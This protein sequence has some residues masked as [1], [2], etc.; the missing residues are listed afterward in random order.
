[1]TNTSRASAVGLHRHKRT[2][3]DIGLALKRAVQIISDDPS[4]RQ[5][6]IL[7]LTDGDFATT[8]PRTVAQS[9]AEFDEAAVEAVQRGIKVYTIALSS[10]KVYDTTRLIDLAQASGGLFRSGQPDQPAWPAGRRRAGA[11]RRARDAP[12]LAHQRGDRQHPRDAGAHHAQP[13][14]GR[15]ARGGDRTAPGALGAAG[16]SPRGRGHR[17][18]PRRRRRGTAAAARAGPVPAAAAGCGVMLS[19]SRPFT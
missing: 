17:G 15:P 14:G 1:M 6:V 19:N 5:P 9:I 10:G 16:L 13:H 8:A 12:A 18:R 7:L 4:E 11:Q 3:T 2:A